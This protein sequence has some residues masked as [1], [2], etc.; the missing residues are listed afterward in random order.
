MSRQSHEK[1]GLWPKSSVSG[2]CHNV[3]GLISTSLSTLSPSVPLSHPVI[4]PQK[5]IGWL[6]WSIFTY[7][8]TKSRG[9]APWPPPSPQTP[10]LGEQPAAEAAG[11]RLLWEPSGCPGSFLGLWA[12]PGGLFL[13]L[14]VLPHLLCVLVL[15]RKGGTRAGHTRLPGEVRGQENGKQRL[16]TTGRAE[17]SAKAS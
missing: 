17:Q 3:H 9:N 15:G 14:L 10:V 11:T 4:V 7:T 6:H 2:Q 5:Q 12:L 1:R 13:Q 16:V 8:N